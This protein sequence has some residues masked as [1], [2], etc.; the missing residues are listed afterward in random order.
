MITTDD[1]YYENSEL[2][3]NRVLTL[4]QSQVLSVLETLCQTLPEGSRIAD[5][6]CGDGII[7]KQI[8]SKYPLLE[9]YGIDMSQEALNHV[10]PPLQ[11]CHSRL[12][13]LP[14][15][16]GFF[17][18][19]FSIDVLEH[20]IP[21]K[22][23]SVIEEVHRICR[24][25]VLLV[26]P[27]LESDAIRTICPYC[28]CVFSP[29]YH[30]NR[31][32]IEA[33]ESLLSKHLDNRN[34]RFLSFGDSKPYI[35]LGVGNLM[36][37]SGSYVTHQHQTVCPQCKTSFSRPKCAS[38]PNLSLLLNP[39]ITQNRNLFG[40]IPE[41]MG[42]LTL[43]SLT[44][45][46]KTI[47][48]ISDGIWMF[49]QENCC[50]SLEELPILEIKS[51]YEIDFSESDLVHSGADLFRKQAYIIDNGE[52]TSSKEFGLIW[53][54]KIHND[55][56]ENTTKT[57]RLVFPLNPE[58]KVVDLELLFTA[59]GDGILKVILYSIPPHT[60][61]EINSIKVN[62]PQK[63]L[64]LS[65]TL[66][67]D[68]QF[69]TPFGLLIDLVWM[70]KSKSGIN[71]CSLQ[72]KKVVD[73]N[74]FPKNLAIAKDTI[75]IP[76]IFDHS[77]QKYQLKIPV[78]ALE[79]LRNLWCVDQGRIFSLYPSLVYNDKDKDK[80]LTLPLLNN[81]YDEKVIDY[82]LQVKGKPIIIQDDCL[83][84]FTIYESIAERLG[85]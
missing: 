22:L 85:Q 75:N 40:L 45:E 3:G 23:P 39:Y 60:S 77:I 26:S 59:Q 4:L 38:Q 35:P 70:P 34:M 19:C 62:S 65:I 42:V 78:Q 10:K 84:S 32:T 73:K 30:L 21:Q 46:E 80:V 8:I 49:T 47:S 51:I 79:K 67:P 63:D 64:C 48:S 37:A 66:S 2:W 24:G 43:P 29:Y 27:F 58:K 83:C 54:F 33:W 74:T 53:K 14:F 28:S 76:H 31:F 1:S 18:L 72:F 16:D 25:V 11:R 41:E 57:L 17:D 15:E 9:G 44:T 50:L 56:S 36:V 6:G 13:T 69:I 68:D 52:L 71:E 7:L 20:I 82:S 12:E 81:F 55:E 61:K 5:L